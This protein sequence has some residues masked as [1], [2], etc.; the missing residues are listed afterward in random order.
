M[1]IIIYILYKFEQNLS[2][3]EISG[4]AGLSFMINPGMPPYPDCDPS[5][6]HLNQTVITPTEIPYPIC[7]ILVERLP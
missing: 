6:C 1:F 2:Q 7:S 5:R 4:L 3:K